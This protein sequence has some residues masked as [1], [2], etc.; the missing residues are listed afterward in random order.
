MRPLRVHELDDRV[1]GQVYFDRAGLIVAERDDHVVGFVHAGF[2][3]DQPI[4]M[5][6]PFSFC[7]SVGT[8]AMLAV[9]PS[10]L[11]DEI[12]R[13]LIIEAERYLA[14]RGTNVIY[15]GGQYPLNPFYWG[16]YGGSEGAGI[17]PSHPGFPRRW[18]GWAMSGS[19]RRCCLN[20]ILRPGP[21]R[22]SGVLISAD[23]AR[24]GGRRNAARLVGESGRRRV[25]PDPVSPPF[26][27][28]ARRASPRTDLGHELVRPFRWPQ[29]CWTLRR[30]GGGGPPS[31]GVR[32]VP[33]LGDLRLAREETTSLVEVQTMLTNAP[34]L[35]LYDSTGIPANRREFAVPPAGSLA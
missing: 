27:I 1:F 33:R 16:L 28:G 6:P 7:E 11:A 30:G 4:E 21:P 23:R 31:P 15:A 12:A 8:I 19:A 14:R 32:P 2:G 18:P 17:V 26:E 34:A 9:E 20:M 35:A 24:V 13:G 5:M 29:P 22:S 10:A 25:S 3:P